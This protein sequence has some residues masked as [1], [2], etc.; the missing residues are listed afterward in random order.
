M[1]VVKLSN[2][3]LE[4]VSLISSWSNT[5]LVLHLVKS[6]SVLFLRVRNLELSFLVAKSL[7]KSKLLIASTLCL[8]CISRT[9]ATSK[10]IDWFDSAVSPIPTGILDN[11]EVSAKFF[12]PDGWVRRF[13]GF[14][15]SF[16][17]IGLFM[18]YERF[19]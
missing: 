1:V 17:P 2:P 18:V 5:L 15:K 8:S 16:H 13:T 4:K 19:W 14:T 6:V 9:F 12:N 3:S 7:T 10:T 11:T